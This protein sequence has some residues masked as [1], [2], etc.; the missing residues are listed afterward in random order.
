[1]SAGNGTASGSAT[2][3]VPASARTDHQVGDLAS[4]LHELR[5]E[6]EQAQALLWSITNLAQ[7]IDYNDSRGVP[8]LSEAIE[9]CAEKADKG[10]ERVVRGIFDRVRSIEVAK[11][12]AHG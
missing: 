8:A 2:H 9:A 4:H 6:V 1:M 12:G 7:R 3:D 5:Q 10:L 11:G